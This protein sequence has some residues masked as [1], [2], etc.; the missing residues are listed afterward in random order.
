MGISGFNELHRL[1]IYIESFLS[2]YKDKFIDKKITKNI[3][4]FISNDNFKKEK[5]KY[6][7][8]L[9]I[10]NLFDEKIL[11]SND[12][13][14]S[15]DSDSDESDIDNESDIYDE[16][17][18]ISEQS[19]LDDDLEHT[20]EPPQ[21]DS[22]NESSDNE[23][24]IDEDDESEE[25][26]DEDDE[27]DNGSD[28]S[29]IGYEKISS[30]SQSGGGE[31]DESKFPNSRYYIKR[32]ENAD[33]KLFKYDS[34]SQ[35]DKY[36]KK[37]Q[38]SNNTQPLALTREEYDN[39]NKELEKYGQ[40]IQQKA[41]SIAGRDPNILYICQEYWDRKNQLIIEPDEDENHPIEDEYI[42]DLI[43]TKKDTDKNKFILHRDNGK[44][45]INFIQNIHPNLYA[46]PCCGK[47]N[48][49]IFRVGEY[50]NVLVSS[51]GE[52]LWIKDDPNPSKRWEQKNKIWEKGKIIEGLSID[53]TY[54]IEVE[55]SVNEY[56]ISMVDKYNDT[57]KLSL[58]F[59]LSQGSNGYVSNLLKNIFHIR[60]NCPNFIQKNMNGFFR[61]GVQQNSESLLS[62][63]LLQINRF[64]RSNIS[65]DDF[66]KSIIK[67]LKKINIYK[68]GGGNFVHSFCSNNYFSD[69]YSLRDFL[70]YEKSTLKDKLLE[71][72]QNF[73]KL[74]D[75]EL[76]NYL[77]NLSQKQQNIINN[78]FIKKST[79]TN[80]KNYLNSNEYKN[81]KIIIS[82][83][84]EISKYE[85]NITLGKHINNLNIII[86]EEKLE[87]VI[88]SDPFHEYNF[89][90]D[91]MFSI[92][93]K[94]E[95]KLE[96][97]IYNYN[98]IKLSLLRYIKDEKIE[99]SKDIIYQNTIGEIIKKIDQEEYLIQIKDTKEEIIINQSEI[100]L[101]DQSEIINI[102]INNIHYKKY[103]F[104]DEQLPSNIL[105][106]IMKQLKF[107]FRNKKSYFDNY[108]KIS[109][110]T[111][112][113]KKNI[114]ILPIK[115][116]NIIDYDYKH[117]Q[118]LPKQSLS[119]IL[120]VLY[121]IDNIIT[122]QDKYSNY[123]NTFLTGEE[124]ILT[125][126]YKMKYL[127]FKNGSFI[128]LNDEKYDFK[129]YKINYLE[130]NSLISLI[131]NKIIEQTK[132][133]PFNDYISNYDILM[134]Q[135]YDLFTNLYLQCR[136]N[137]ETLD[138]IKSIKNHP[139]KLSIHKREEIL[140]EIENL[141]KKMKKKRNLN[142]KLIQKNP[143]NNKIKLETYNLNLSLKK[144]K[145][146]NPKL[147]KKFVENIYLNNIEDL[148]K[149]FIYTY[150]SLNKIN[151]ES[152]N[153]YI[154]SQKQIL[155]NEH[156]RVFLN[157]SLYLRNISYYNI[158]NPN[159]NFTLLNL[160]ENNNLVSFYTNYPNI[161]K[162]YFG[163]IKIYKLF[164]DSINDFKI[165]DYALEDPNNNDEIIKNK[166]IQ[167]IELNPEII[168]EYN[169]WQNKNYLTEKE[170]INDINNIN[171][172]ITY[173]DLYIISELLSDIEN[174]HKFGFCLFTNQYSYNPKKYELFIIINEEVLK[175]S[176]NNIELICL[177]QD[178]NNDDNKIKNILFPNKKRKTT[179]ENLY[180]KPKFKKIWDEEYN[181]E[182]N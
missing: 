18:N 101:F 28:D 167:K 100:I 32:L 88:I 151:K 113:N 177:Y 156:V 162:S 54:L 60:D 102:I 9:N 46:L 30:S 135:E 13:D 154:F 52:P 153:D 14:D 139:I 121:N 159:L 47:K 65:L 71:D 37:C 179:L 43:Y 66:K 124:I 123:Y 83:F 106:E 68:I 29:D 2:I 95:D 24:D 104:K 11:S 55:G 109:H 173:T 79:I 168:N 105:I 70:K 51:D 133:T 157:Y 134:N 149:L 181:L 96:P 77:H 56:H 155:N 166:L 170:L 108:Y 158:H 39:I 73:K 74:N 67:D 115:P 42:G 93:Y 38:S 16:Y 97:L 126:N 129:K 50:V 76:L 112:M 141:I 53:D 8:Y 34:K 89:D 147:L 111:F 130:N 122:S 48:K 31:D 132:I 99:L 6:L 142:M 17:D 176:L 172:N 127:Y 78:D 131:E 169:H 165:I 161:I 171:Y 178:I 21:Q 138:N 145:N 174:D 25:D 98:N 150:L 27:S 1:M 33:L 35:K 92:I 180:L 160:K 90:E 114:I 69:K 118:Y 41:F 5:D 85:D 36:A 117:I 22:D 40:Q 45:E 146:I 125:Q 86:L 23:E 107:I 182:L 44:H 7:S 80:F 10:E 128:K 63:I 137:K 163:E 143:D 61:I 49:N 119:D 136:N 26:I 19:D 15:D 4:K 58:S 164:T 75:I 175:G 103:I 91:S 148:D 12:S 62:C 59:P 72:K 57:G 82:L 20:D 87:K 140:S 152:D 144:I 64:N 116:E 84:N 120:N 3:D 94:R 81:E 110:L